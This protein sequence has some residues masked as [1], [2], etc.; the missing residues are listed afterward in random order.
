MKIPLVGL[1]AAALAACQPSPPAAQAA[2]GAPA[3]ASAAAPFAAR[4]E[5]HDA[6]FDDYR[7][8]DGETLPHLRLH[9]STLGT[10]RRDAARFARGPPQS[11]TRTTSAIRTTARATV[12]STRSSATSDAAMPEASRAIAA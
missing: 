6:T 12:M 1:L 7:F 3:P 11:A 5:P 2:P 9:Y 10:P 4:F 8:R